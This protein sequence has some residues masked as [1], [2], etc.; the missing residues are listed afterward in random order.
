LSFRAGN[1]SVMVVN[2]LG[3]EGGL[4]TRSGSAANPFLPE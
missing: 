4:F 3:P 1:P 2:T